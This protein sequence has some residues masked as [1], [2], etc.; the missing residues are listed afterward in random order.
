[1]APFQTFA[2]MLSPLTTPVRGAAQLAMKERDVQSQRMVVKFREAQIAS[3]EELAA[4]LQEED[5]LAPHDSR[6]R[7]LAAENSSLRHEAEVRHGSP[8]STTHAQHSAGRAKDAQPRSHALTPAF[9]HF[10]LHSGLE[11]AH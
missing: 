8:P 10:A 2:S 5:G 9:S 4:M 6:V 11:R 3:L 7:A 1:L